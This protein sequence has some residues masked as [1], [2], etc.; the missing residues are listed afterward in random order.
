MQIIKYELKTR[1][2]IFLR[3]L[4]SLI[5]QLMDSMNFHWLNCFAKMLS[6]EVDILE[7]SKF[8]NRWNYDQKLIYLTWIIYDELNCLIENMKD[9][10]EH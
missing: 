5:K 8:K 7:T 10:N 9:S 6:F 2:E 1:R 3:L 4:N